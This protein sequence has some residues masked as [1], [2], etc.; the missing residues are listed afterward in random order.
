[1][2]MMMMTMTAITIMVTTKATNTKAAA[3]G[4]VEMSSELIWTTSY[5][6]RDELGRREKERYKMKENLTRDNSMKIC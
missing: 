4:V 5:H 1:M 3:R 6:F 2:L